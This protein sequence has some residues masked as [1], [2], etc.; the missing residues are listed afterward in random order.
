[1]HDLLTGVRWPWQGLT[2]WVRLDPQDEP[3]HIF[4]L[5]QY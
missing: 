2:G 5:E 4:R 1:M 3:V